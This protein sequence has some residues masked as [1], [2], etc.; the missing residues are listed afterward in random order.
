MTKY[1]YYF[2]LCSINFFFLAIYYKYTAIFFLFLKDGVEDD[3]EAHIIDPDE[4]IAHYD[5]SCKQEDPE[6]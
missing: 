5:Y 2:K 6:L 4:G 3:D 1:N